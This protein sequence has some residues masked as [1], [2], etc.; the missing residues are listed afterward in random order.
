MKLKTNTKAGIKVGGY[1]D[2]NHN[3]SPT[4]KIKSTLRAGVKTGGY[5]ETNHN[6]SPTR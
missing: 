6:Q 4:L 2:N 1:S 3:Q 5:S